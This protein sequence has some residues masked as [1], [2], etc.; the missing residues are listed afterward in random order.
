M[1]KTLEQIK[2]ISEMTFRH[3]AIQL[4]TG[5]YCDR[6]DDMPAGTAV[7]W[8]SASDAGYFE[9]TVTIGDMARAFLQHQMDKLEKI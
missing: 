5:I 2:E 8:Q 1:T 6:P 4:A 3:A 9:E 7:A